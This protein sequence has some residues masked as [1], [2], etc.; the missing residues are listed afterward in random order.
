MLQI[1]KSN[2]TNI[3]EHKTFVQTYLLMYWFHGA[4]TPMNTNI[5][6]PFKLLINVTKSK[7]IH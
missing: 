7:N 2:Y 6:I 1:V 4:N 3:T 5:A